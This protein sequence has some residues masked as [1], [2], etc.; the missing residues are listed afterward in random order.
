MHTQE[1]YNID[2]TRL[3]ARTRS[4]DVNICHITHALRLLACTLSAI[5]D[6]DGLGGR[7]DIVTVMRRACVENGG[8]DGENVTT[9]VQVCACPETPPSEQVC[10]KG[11]I[12]HPAAEDEYRKKKDEGYSHSGCSQRYRDSWR[13]TL[14]QAKKAQVRLGY[15]VPRS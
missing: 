13:F 6:S 7:D 5:H 10:H 11:N 3:H 1:C 15:C 12:T 14:W 2:C 4:R 9:G 8:K